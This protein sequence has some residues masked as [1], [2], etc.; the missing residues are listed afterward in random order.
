MFDFLRPH[1]LGPARLLCP[2]NSPGKN[3]GVG[4]HFLLLQGRSPSGD[5]ADPGIG[6]GSPLLP[7]DSLL[8]EPPGRPKLA[9]LPRFKREDT[10]AF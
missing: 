10:S 6:P 1:G 3:T 4:S 8:S 2:W 9:S 5:L 7:A